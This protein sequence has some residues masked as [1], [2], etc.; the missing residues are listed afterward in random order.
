MKKKTKYTGDKGEIVG[1]L[2]PIPDFLPSPEELAKEEKTV[3]V[4]IALSER[5]VAYFK[6]EAEAHGASY[7]KM[8]RRL[9]DIYAH[10]VSGDDKHDDSSSNTRAK[11]KRVVA[12]IYKKKHSYK[13]NSK[14][15]ARTKSHVKS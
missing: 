15:A 5:S 2:H 8:I 9:V 13:M 4:T 14:K 6:H 10:H 12:K 7:Q 11:T 1:R 3:K